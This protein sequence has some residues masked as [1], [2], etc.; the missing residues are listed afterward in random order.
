VDFLLLL[1][2]FFVGLATE[3]AW[4]AFS[5]RKKEKQGI[6]SLDDTPPPVFCAEFSIAWDGN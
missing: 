4:R 5:E 6:D 3:S 1:G 2:G